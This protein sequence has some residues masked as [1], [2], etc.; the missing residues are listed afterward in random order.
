MVKESSSFVLVIPNPVLITVICFTALCLITMKRLPGNIIFYT[1]A[2][3]AALAMAHEYIMPQDDLYNNF[4]TSYNL[5]KNEILSVS[6]F[7]A[8]EGTVE[9]IYYT[10]VALLAG[11]DRSQIIYMSVMLSAVFGFLAIIFSAKLVYAWTGNMQLS[12]LLVLF[13]LSSGYIMYNLYCG[14]GYNL[15]IFLVMAGYYLLVKEKAKFA[16]YIFSILPAIRPEGLFILPILYITAKLVPLNKFT[17]RLPNMAVIAWFTATLL[18]FL[19]RRLYY[20]HWSPV[21]GLSKQ[22]PLFHWPAILYGANRLLVALAPVLIL[23][24]AVLIFAAVVYRHRQIK[25]DFT[26]WS[27]FIP[28]LVP[29]LVLTGAYKFN[30]G[31]FLFMNRYDLPLLIV[32]SVLLLISC[33]KLLARSKYAPHFIIICILVINTA[34]GRGPLYYSFVE[35]HIPLK[36]FF[37]PAQ[38][39]Q[40][41]GAEYKE[42][43]AYFFNYLYPD[44]T[45]RIGVVELNTF[46]YFS[47]HRIFD[48]L[49][50]TNKDI[51]FSQPDPR[52]DLFVGFKKRN[53]RVIEKYDLDMIVGRHANYWNYD[54]NFFEHIRKADT[55]N[56]SYFGWGKGSGEYLL[57]GEAYLQANG[58]YPGLLIFKNISF[59][60][61][62]T[63]DALLSLEN[64]LKDTIPYRRLL[65]RYE[66]ETHDPDLLVIK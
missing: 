30:G 20:G 63:P 51:A 5:M 46:G 6:Q 16:I 31:D 60:V 34:A 14:Y 8:Q 45:K 48:L 56:H 21:P 25:P 10:L 66:Q 33:G 17:L 4:L 55:L 65:K 58:Y 35:R 40:R 28:V 57:G 3:L 27:K 54:P 15:F 7:E 42:G 47:R 38:Y 61:Y 64:R 19:L 59:S 23:A 24:L 18:P 50:T 26:D 9:Y 43:L 52:M 12:R 11:D 44:E 39:F 13:F 22:A 62:F 1:F 36:Q 37:I 2:A 32:L 29:I 49:G 53:P 41:V